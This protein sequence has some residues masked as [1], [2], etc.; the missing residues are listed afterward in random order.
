M[1]QSS[2]CL[3][4][5]WLDGGR[6]VDVGRSRLVAPM[7]YGLRPSGYELAIPAFSPPPPLSLAHG[8]RPKGCNWQV[9]LLSAGNQGHGMSLRTRRHRQCDTVLVCSGS[10]PPP[11]RSPV[12]PPAWPPHF[13]VVAPPAAG[14][15]CVHRV[16]DGGSLRVYGVTR[17]GRLVLRVLALAAAAATSGG[18]QQANP[19]PRSS[20]PPVNVASHPPS[21]LRLHRPGQT[22][23]DLDRILSDPK[24]G[25]PES[26]HE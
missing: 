23:A 21:Q 14:S 11:A 8:Y 18:G 19:A 9:T 26:R 7:G 22:W 13:L 3:T 12:R 20:R 25:P 17:Y 16:L 2:L 5:S 4:A 10:S 6:H 15:Y 24:G 1:C